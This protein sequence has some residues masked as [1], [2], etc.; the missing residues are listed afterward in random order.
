MITQLQDLLKSIGLPLLIIIVFFAGRFTAV[1][2]PCQP[3]VQI[4]PQVIETEVAAPVIDLTTK[5]QARE[6]QLQQTI[7]ALRAEAKKPRPGKADSECLSETD[8]DLINQAARVLE[9]TK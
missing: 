5:Y 3:V 9:L 4:K 7:E 2:K 1:C 8:L 6:K